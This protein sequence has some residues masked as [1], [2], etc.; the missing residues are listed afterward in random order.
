[1]DLTDIFSSTIQQIK[2]SINW[3]IETED[4]AI[5]KQ[6][7]I[8]LSGAELIKLGYPEKV[9]P[10]KPGYFWSID[11]YG[12]LFHTKQI[13]FHRCGDAICERI[14]SELML[15]ALVQTPKLDYVMFEATDGGLIYD[16]FSPVLGEKQKTLEEVKSNPISD[17][18]SEIITSGVRYFEPVLQFIGF[19]DCHDK[20]VLL[21]SWY[22]NGEEKN[23]LYLI[24]FSK[25]EFGFQEQA[26]LDWQ[27]KNAAMYEHGVRAIEHI[28]NSQIATI[29]RNAYRE[30]N[31][32][33]M[34]GAKADYIIDV[35]CSSREEVLALSDTKISVDPEY[36]IP[37]IP[38]HQLPTNRYASAIR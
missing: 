6:G 14:G 36:R 15:A 30:F 8:R 13:G 4:D 33:K 3:A 7:Y 10:Y 20:N 5:S 19:V 32:N 23:G 18:L 2:P 26:P 29:V 38:M 9:K 21:A 34:Y 1:M 16:C 25:L 28:K 31:A 17:S 11:K 35:L 12:H 37:S 22:D 24:D 27:H